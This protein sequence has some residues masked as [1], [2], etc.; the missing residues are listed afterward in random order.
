MKRI[1]KIFAVLALPVS[2]TFCT[3]PEETAQEPAVPPVVEFAYPEEGISAVVEAPVTFEADITSSG[4]V[5]CFWAID[6]EKI[7]STPTVTWTFMETGEYTLHFEAFNEAGTFGKDFAVKVTGVD[8]VVEFSPEPD[9]PIGIVMNETITVTATPVS[10]NRDVV[11]S[12]KIGDKEVSTDA[13]LSY[14]FDEAGEF[15]LTYTGTNHYGLTTTASWPVSVDELPLEVE[16]SVTEPQIAIRPG[17]N[18]EIT[19]TAVNGG[20]GLVH[21]WKIDDEEVSDDAVFS[22]VFE[23]AGT[24]D[25]S[26]TGTNAKGETVTH[27][28]TVSVQ[29]LKTFMYDDFEVGTAVFPEGYDGN[30]N[31]NVFVCSIVDNP[32]PTDANP[33]DKVLVDDLSWNNGGTSGYVTIKID[34]DGEI[35]SW[36]DRKQ[37][38]KIAMKVYLGTN[39]YY[40]YLQIDLAPTPKSLPSEINGEPFD[41]KNPDETAWKR[42]VKTDDWNVFVYDLVNGNYKDAFADVSEFGQI[43]F[44]PL[45]AIDGSSAPA[46][47]DP[48]TNTKKVWIDDIQFIE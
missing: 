12:W 8:L 5:E 19:A 32:Y 42:L 22:H 6:D 27:G 23:N 7:G 46:A 24:F 15:T 2:V 14:A 35:I 43:Q 39:D 21:S 34:A 17:D 3:A 26:Y 25:L 11:H 37:Y 28:W 47:I 18:V 9:T 20:A 36:A 45:S 29:A 40:P 1:L 31:A 30:K 13:V 41:A 33:S 4:P 16:F 10:G 44:R 38:T 48:V